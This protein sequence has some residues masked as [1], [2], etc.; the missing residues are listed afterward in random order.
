M[1]VL[2]KGQSPFL[3]PLTNFPFLSWLPSSLSFR[4]HSPYILVPKPER[5]D[6]PQLGGFLSWAHF[7]RSPPSDLAEKMRRA[8]RRNSQLAL[9]DRHPHTSPH[10][11]HWLQGWVKS[12]SLRSSL[13]PHFQVLSLG[14][15]IPMALG[16]LALCPIWLWNRGH[17]FQSRLLLLSEKVLRTGTPVLSDLCPR[18]LSPLSNLPIQLQWE[19]LNSSPQNLLL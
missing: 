9:L 4:L 15:M 2:L 8:P 11:I 7:Q 14:G 17:P 10:F 5:K 3:F 18:F 6:P 19:I 13:S 12:H 16:P 1:L